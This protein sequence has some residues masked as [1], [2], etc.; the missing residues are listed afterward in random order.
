MNEEKRGEAP[1]YVP[2]KTF[3]SATAQLEGELPPR[4]DPSVFQT[5]SGGTTSQLLS[6]FRFLGFTEADG[7]VRELFRS[8][9][10]AP[11]RRSQIMQ[12][13]LA[14]KYSRQLE[15]A[16]QSATPRQMQTLFSEMG[17][18]GST[19]QKAVRFFIQACHFADV[20]IPPTWVGARAPSSTSPKGNTSRKRRGST[21]ADAKNQTG[22]TDTRTTGDVIEVTLESGGIVKLSVATSLTH[23]SQHDR[24]WLFAT[25][26]QVRSYQ[27]RGGPNDE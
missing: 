13:V 9:V 24:E 17:V 7:T 21:K 15:L 19:L 20:P 10:D 26:D 1:A 14:D 22:E 16:G 25:I 5:Y 23:L 8:W 2:W 6:A 4:I 12:G 11:D 18:R 27:P 3:L